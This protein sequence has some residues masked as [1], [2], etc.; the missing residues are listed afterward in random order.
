MAITE[1]DRYE[2]FKALEEVLGRD[3]ASTLMEH[4]PPVGWADVATTRDLE[5]L[6]A[7]IDGRF[8]HIDAR[9]ALV[10]GRFEQVEGKIAQMADQLRAEWRLDTRNIVLAVVASNATFAALVIAATRLS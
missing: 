7:R 6:E 3:R 8:A 9:F 10:D 1:E 4:L 5:H 2:L